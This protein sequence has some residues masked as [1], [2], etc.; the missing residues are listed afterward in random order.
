MSDSYPSKKKQIFLYVFYAACAI[1]AVLALGLGLGL[2]L[3]SPA[4]CQNQYANG[5]LIGTPCGQSKN[6]TSS[7]ISSGT[8]SASS[9][10]TASISARAFLD[11]REMLGGAVLA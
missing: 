4:K 10:A 3:K 2:G 6:S 11:R 1:C 8:S 7:A 9:S 5:K